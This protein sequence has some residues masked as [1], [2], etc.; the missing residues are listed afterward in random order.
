MDVLLYVII[1]YHKL[2]QQPTVSYVFFTITCNCDGI[3]WYLQSNSD[4]DKRKFVVNLLFFWCS[5][6]DSQ[7]IIVTA[8]KIL[9]LWAEIHR[10]GEDDIKFSLKIWGHYRKI[11]TSKFAEIDFCQLNRGHVSANP[12]FGQSFTRTHDMKKFWFEDKHTR[13]VSL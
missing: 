11:F 5:F 13:N 4:T 2:A 7:L 1:S 12:V 8:M 6:M 10:S 3:S 9:Q